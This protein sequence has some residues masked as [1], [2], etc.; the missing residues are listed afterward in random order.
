ME[1]NAGEQ[2]N[3]SGMS[4]ALVEAGWGRVPGSSLF[5]VAWDISMGHVGLHMETVIEGIQGQT[6]QMLGSLKHS[7]I[8]LDA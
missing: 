6:G 5:Q 4:R 3:K 8:F 1:W 7:T 2:T